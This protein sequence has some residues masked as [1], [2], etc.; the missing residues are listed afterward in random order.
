MNARIV[1]F[2]ACRLF[3]VYL[4]IM[5]GVSFVI[6]LVIASLAPRPEDSEGVI[7]QYILTAGVATALYML[8]A[9]GLW[10]GAS[11]I[12]RTVSAPVPEK[13]E[14]K[15]AGDRWQAVALSAVGWLTLMLAAGQSGR[16]ISAFIQ[17]DGSTGLSP[18]V[19]QCLVLLTLGGGF[20]LF[21][22]SVVRGLERFRAWGRKPLIAAEDQ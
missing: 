5:Y 19:V 21:S 3:A 13:F 22:R 12:S 7:G 9:F 18:N 1:A 2:V 14:D 8:L 20:T 17:T 6:Q 10:T 16:L 11:W 4:L 15:P